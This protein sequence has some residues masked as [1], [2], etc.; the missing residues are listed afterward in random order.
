M[1]KRN[2]GEELC[3]ELTRIVPKSQGENIRYAAQLIIRNEEHKNTLRNQWFN[4]NSIGELVDRI[5]KETESEQS[6]LKQY[7]ELRSTSISDIQYLFGEIGREPIGVR[8]LFAFE[9]TYYEKA[10]E[11]FG[12]DKAARSM[13][14]EKIPL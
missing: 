14:L 9:K 7:E 8:E 11:K 1:I 5:M 4:G 2:V 10:V 3:F 13:G 12:A 6:L